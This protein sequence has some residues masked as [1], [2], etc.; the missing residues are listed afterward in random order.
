MIRYFDEIEIGDEITP[1]NK[2]AT[3]QMLVKW[4][5]ASGDYNPVHFDDEFARAQGLASQIVHGP[6]KFAW[7]GQMLTEWVGEA[8]KIKKLSAQFRGLDYPRRMKTLSE[9]SEGETWWCKG[10]VVGKYEQNHED[11]IDCQVWVENGQ[12][13]KTVMGKAVVKLPRLSKR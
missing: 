8:G 11:L 13:E 5:G 1:L 4:A 9:P 12:A 10:T 6:L 3:T 7:L 2:V